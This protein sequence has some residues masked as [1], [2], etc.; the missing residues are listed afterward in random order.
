MTLIYPS[1]DPGYPAATGGPVTHALVI[2]CGRFPHFNSTKAMDRKS[3]VAG[4]RAMVQ[5]LR[6]RGADFLAPLA[7]I[8]CLV[9]DPD[10][11]PGEDTVEWEEHDAAGV[12]SKVSAAVRPVLLADVQAAAR[13]WLTRCR[14]GD[15]MFF[16]MSTHGIADG[17]AALGLCEDVLSNP[18]AKWSQ[19]LN[20]TTLAQGVLVAGADRA[21][22]FFDACQEIDQALLGAPTGTPGF[23]LVEY[24]LSDLTKL[25]RRPLA[26]AGSRLG[27]RAWAPKDGKAP[28]FFTQALLEGLTNACVEQ[29]AGLGWVVTGAQLLFGLKQVADA[30]LE[31][32]V[33]TEPLHIFNEPRLGLLTI[34]APEVPVKIR[35]ETEAHFAHIAS[36]SVE[37]SDNSI[38][39]I[40]W[41]RPDPFELAWRFRVKADRLHQ[42]KAS[43]VFANAGVAYNAEEFSAMPPAQVVVL[44]P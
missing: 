32:T 19:S 28:P 8:E 11:K 17:S 3:T 31:L 43:L 39:P 33:E 38:A 40:P 21:W 27:G 18:F 4:A 35:T 25:K 15:H 13:T 42:Y 6:D 20:V 26:L 7:T 30:T 5:F 14:P 23:N 22:V 9:S 10:A 37:C 44:K 2:G 16:Y 41:V 34:P 24:S 29:V 12:A 1:A 36:G